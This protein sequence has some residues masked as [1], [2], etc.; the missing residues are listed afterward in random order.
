[1]TY[2]IPALKQN[3]E[4]EF[5]CKLLQHSQSIVTDY[6]RQYTEDIYVALKLNA[7]TLDKQPINKFVRSFLQ[8]NFDNTNIFNAK[9][10]TK[11]EELEKVI[12]KCPGINAQEVLTPELFKYFEEALEVCWKLVLSEPAFELSFSE[13]MF[14]ED[15]H[16]RLSNTDEN[17]TF[18]KYYIFP[19]LKQGNE[20][21][22]KAKVKI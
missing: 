19:Y 8:S 16:E 9:A 13:N 21:H 5:I 20:I 7:D 10:L 14:N 2:D 12:N 1:L 22:V 4:Q 11:P 15:I 3:L 17:S 6:V 18:I